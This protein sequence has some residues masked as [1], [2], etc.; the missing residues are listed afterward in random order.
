[1]T[2]SDQTPPAG[3]VDEQWL[4]QLL[5]REAREHRDR[6]VGDEGFSARVMA[7]LP[8]P[9]AAVPNWRK[10]VVTGMWAIAGIAFAYALP[11]AV[12]DVAREAFVL[13]SAKPFSLS[14]I[15]AMVGALA[16]VTYGGAA[17]ALRRD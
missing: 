5:V 9:V 2:D 10:P 15:G 7:A 17:L 3:S 11:G 12:H 8:A 1:M 4:E 14:A 16:I 6:Y 13:L